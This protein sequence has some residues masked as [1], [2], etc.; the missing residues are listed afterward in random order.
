MIKLK[1]LIFEQ[2]VAE[3][4][5]L[6]EDIKDISKAK[7]I[8]RQIQGA[9]MRMRLHMDKLSDKMWSPQNEKLSLQLEKSYQKNVTKFMREMMSL[10]KRMK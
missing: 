7:K 8:R 5:K 10:V 2:E 6:N 3:E 9:E 4:E 1:N